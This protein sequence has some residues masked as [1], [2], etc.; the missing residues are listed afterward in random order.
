M[1][2]G[3]IIRVLEGIELT[4]D[5]KRALGELLP[6]YK[7]GNFI[8]ETFKEKPE[9]R[10]NIERRINSLHDA[11][12]F[13]LEAYPPD[14]AFTFVTASTL[15]DYAKECRAACNLNKTSLTDLHKELEQFTVKL[16]NLIFVYWK[17]DEAHA[18]KKAAALLNDAEQ[19][20]ILQQGR[21]DL[22]TLTMSKT[23]AGIEYIV[24]YDR[25]LPSDYPLLINE[26]E[27]VRKKGYPKT[28][29]WFSGLKDYYQ[30]FFCNFKFSQA[31]PEAI[32]SEAVQTLN[33]IIDRWG[34]AK[35]MALSLS[36]DLKQIST[37]ANVLPG[38]FNKLT[39]PGKAMMQILAAGG[40]ARVSTKLEE[41]KKF[42]IEH[43]RS[44]E[45]KKTLAM[46]SEIPQW[47]WV[48]PQTQQYFLQY[49]LTKT[50]NAA[51][52]IAFISSR[53][54]MLPAPANF[55]AHSLY[56]IDGQGKITPFYRERLRF[57]H[58]ASRDVVKLPRAVQRRHVDSNLA[59][60]EEIASPNQPMLVQTLIS[61]LRIQEWVPG[62]V[63][64]WAKLP[65]DLDLYKL[66]DAAIKR[67]QNHNVL[68][69][70][71]PYNIAKII[72][73]TATDDPHSQSILRLARQYKSIPEMSELIDLY[74]LVLRS[75]PGGAWIRDYEGRELF[76]SSIEHLLML[77]LGGLSSGSCVSGKDRKAV[78][79]IHTDAMI[80]YKDKYGTWPRFDRADESDRENF[81]KIVVD[82]YVSRHQHRHAGQ[83]APGSEGIKTPQWYWP[84]DIV[85]AIKK[86][87]DD[88]DAAMKD[89]R[90]ASDNEVMHIFKKD[91][92]GTLVSSK[93]EEH[94]DL[95]ARQLGEKLCTALYSSLHYL[96]SQKRLFK[97]IAPKR[98]F[99]STGWLSVFST[100]ITGLQAI[101]QIME[102]EKAGDT[103]V[104]RFA[105]V[106]LV[107]TQRQKNEP[108]TTD[109]TILVYER[110]SAIASAPPKSPASEMD[111]M[112][113]ATE[114]AVKWG[115]LFEQ[116]QCATAPSLSKS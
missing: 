111:L 80:L 87:L 79:L 98:L 4:P 93:I 112:S 71:H 62:F 86:R 97:S 100:P 30:A 41:L 49:I 75:S 106:L 42:I 47:Y 61:P 60:I 28:P 37:E 10:L 2:K 81:V 13:I 107:I 82:L 108:S 55:A 58:L 65:P 12:N 59:K 90:I 22:A 5:L 102:N 95:I 38:W 103:N 104:R 67:R 18:I 24:Q 113:Y 66:L 99:T 34:D 29:S 1:A 69:H 115:E 27:L 36:S 52:A 31:T 9:Y 74:E 53:L 116:S 33:E 70:N 7:S 40:S 19:Y 63:D 96:I 46:V 72:Y 14:P 8:L 23:D 20:N 83:N 51:D 11:F 39:P 84:G 73:Y 85:E 64:E 105:Q 48:L 110:L 17:W 92:L 6:D 94:C 21:Y 114:T 88:P 101:E 54:R 43:S 78:E 76:L 77:T 15:A 32:T 91:E 26:L 50:P 35:A 57:S 44:A 16:I 89:D 109:A 56:K 45:F 3:T 68:Q 25:S